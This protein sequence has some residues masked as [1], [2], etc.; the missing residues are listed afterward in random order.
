VALSITENMPKPTSCHEPTIVAMP[1]QTIAG[2]WVFPMYR[3][4]SSSA[5]NAHHGSNS[6]RLGTR[7]SR[8]GVE[9][10]VFM[11]ERTGSSTWPHE[12][13][14]DPAR[15]AESTTSPRLGPRDTGPRRLDHGYVAT[16]SRS[17]LV[18]W[19]V[20]ATVLVACQ[21]DRAGR[22]A[23]PAVEQPQ[24]EEQPPAVEQSP[25]G[26]TRPCS[27]A[28]L[29]ARVAP[30]ALP[31]AV[32]AMRERIVA[33]AVACDT[34]ALERLALEG[35]VGFSFS[36][37]A[38]PGGPAEHWRRQEAE[39]DARPLAKL[40]RV[41]AAPHRR[42]DHDGEQLYVWPSTFGVEAPT[43]EDWKAIDGV[44]APEEIARMQA[45]TERFGIG[46]LG[47]RAGITG[48]GDWIYFIAGD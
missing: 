46:Y 28:G 26:T 22:P 6:S 20:A 39:G 17:A 3:V 35:P 2:A 10:T 42:I 8:R 45:D 32:A 15:P 1:R 38:P 37:G 40:V 36:F 23:P 14:L 44:Y 33:A 11:R 27:A 48:S 47:Y 4:A 7:N 5:M 34:A 31:A 13:R 29:E 18:S 12:R 41:L 43:A 21:A 30:Q 16:R 25:A 24:A 9:I 19:A